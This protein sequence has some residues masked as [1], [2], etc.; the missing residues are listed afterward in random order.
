MKRPHA[1]TL[2]ELLI[3]VAIVAVLAAI[4]VP[5]FLEAQT[6]SKVSRA[7]ADMRT[8]ATGLESYRVD[9]QR[10]PDP[11]PNTTAPTNFERR[12]HPLTTPIAYL[13]D[14]PR[15]TFRHQFN[16]GATN[17]DLH[18]APGGDTLVYGRGDKAG[19][20]ATIDFG[21]QYLMISSAGPDNRLDHLHY[22][23][24]LA[25]FGGSD[26]PICGPELADLLAVTVYDPTNG[27]ISAGDLYRWSSTT[28]AH[29]Q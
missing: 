22:Y 13:A 27:T 19:D 5:N 15:D 6:R 3:V 2:I 14:V 4:A 17:I 23:P 18:N 7:L 11:L 9:Q 28:H 26:C 29:A 12:L 25:G 8:V 10:L 1:F 24:P 16:N 20:R 21:P